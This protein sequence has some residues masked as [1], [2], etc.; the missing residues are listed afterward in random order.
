M[1]FSVDL[2]TSQVYQLFLNLCYKLKL[3]L[4]NVSLYLFQE[5]VFFLSPFWLLFF[6]CAKR[7]LICIADCYFDF[8]NEYKDHGQNWFVPLSYQRSSSFPSLDRRVWYTDCVCYFVISYEI[9]LSNLSVCSAPYWYLILTWCFS[10]DRNP[11]LISFALNWCCSWYFTT[12]HFASASVSTIES[13]TAYSLPSGYVSSA[14]T[15]LVIFAHCFES[16]PRYPN[17]VWQGG[18]CSGW[19]CWMGSSFDLSRCIIGNGLPCLGWELSYLLMLHFYDFCPGRRWCCPLPCSSFVNS[20]RGHSILKAE[21]CQWSNQ[22]C[23]KPHRCRSSSLVAVL[24][25][26]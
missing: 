13:S 23:S 12:D 6:G 24:W 11:S 8:Q 9:L 18:F 25:H 26:H 14:Y 7:M 4:H 21:D 2:Q 22:L 20:T 1:Y 17:F 5:S 15:T 10:Y 19:A 16:N 3:L